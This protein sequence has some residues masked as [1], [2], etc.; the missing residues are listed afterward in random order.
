MKAREKTLAYLAVG[1]VLAFLVRAILMSIFFAP[2]NEIDSKIEKTKQKIALKNKKMQPGKKLIAEWNRINRTTLAD[3]PQQVRR[4]LLGRINALTSLSGLQNVT[5]NPIPIAPKKAGG[6][7]RYYPVAINI[8]GKGTLAQIV[9]FLEM[10]Y[11]E[12]YIV[13]I[14]GITL[15]SDAKGNMVS[16]SNCRIETIVLPKPEMKIRKQKIV[17][18]KITTTEPA[19]SV[20]S[21]TKYSVITA[22]N[23]FSPAILPSAPSVNQSPSRKLAAQRVAPQET[24][25]GDL[26]ATVV[27]GNE[28]GAYIR[29]QNETQ[30]YKKGDVLPG[31]LRLEFVHPLGIVLKD[32]SNRVVYI[33][34][35]K[36]IDD[37]GALTKGSCPELYEAYQRVLSDKR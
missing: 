16:F 10:F 3:D 27:I 32:S 21:D 8:T 23:I 37:P 14:T 2:L 22:R 4:I 9:K 24:K 13:K 33:E 36:N 35:G 25:P 20:V 18:K 15:R 31:N 7:I 19:P 11:R 17:R 12:P 5:K 1:I 29:N 28:M 26:V 6:I 34:I 30:W